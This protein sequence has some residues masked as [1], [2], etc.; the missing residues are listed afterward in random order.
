MLKLEKHQTQ[1]AAERAAEA[2]LNRRGISTAKTDGNQPGIDL[3]AIHAKGPLVPLEVKGQQGRGKSD[4]YV[5]RPTRDDTLYIFVHV[6]TTELE[7]AGAFE[8]F[9]MDAKEVRE[10]MDKYLADRHRRGT[11]D[12]KW[13]DS[14]RWRDAE[15]YKNCWDKLAPRD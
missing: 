5:A 12:E 7:K 15:P 6:H 13:H 9:V 2:E 3:V 8:F 1:R 10:A 4:W 14:I 11:S